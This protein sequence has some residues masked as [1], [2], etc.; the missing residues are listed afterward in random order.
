M[1][2]RLRIDDDIIHTVNY[3]SWFIIFIIYTIIIDQWLS[4]YDVMYLALLV[5]TMTLWHDHQVILNPNT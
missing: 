3:E 1:I 5:N 2:K 4:D